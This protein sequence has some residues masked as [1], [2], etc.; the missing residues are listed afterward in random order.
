MYSQKIFRESRPEKLIDTIRSI[1]AMS[2]VTSGPDGLISTFAPV[3]IEGPP[4]RPMVVG[5]IAKANPQWRDTDTT[6]SALAIAI[7]ANGY[8]SPNWYSTKPDDPRVVPT[9]NHVHI[10]AHGRVEFLPGRGDCLEIVRALTDV[11]ESTMP[12]PWS[13]DDAPDDFI[14]AKLAGIVGFRL[15]VER[16]EGM[17]K[18]SQNQSA[19]NRA[20]VIGALTDSSDV[21]EVMTTVAMD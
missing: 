13:V 8:V 17:F 2:L 9:W 4:E 10:Q 6:Q 21:A 3:M 1:G 7:G 15:H 19:E 12:K 14:D 16:L 18:M 20:G 5:H 11:H